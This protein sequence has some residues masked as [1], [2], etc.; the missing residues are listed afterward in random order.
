MN[1]V[2]WNTLAILG[3]IA[4]AAGMSALWLSAQFRRLEKTFYAEMDKHRREG[5]V[6]FDDHGKRIQRL[7][8]KNFGFT[9]D[10]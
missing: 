8:I 7:E 2:D 5:N 9:R 10:H 3:T 1:Q 4:S 6:Q